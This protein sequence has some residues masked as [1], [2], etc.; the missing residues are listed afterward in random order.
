[1]LLLSGCS[2][3][4]ADDL[5]TGKDGAGAPNDASTDGAGEALARDG[6]PAA[7]DSDGADVTQPTPRRPTGPLEVTEGS[8]ITARVQGFFQLEM[9]PTSGFTPSRL[10]DLG[11]PSYPS[12]AAS[13]FEPIATV[14]DGAVVGNVTATNAGYFEVL[15]ETPA[16]FSFT[17]YAHRELASGADAKTTVRCSIYA[18]GRVVLQTNIQNDGTAPL[19]LPQGWRHSSF[20]VDPTKPWRV[21]AGGDERSF[22]FFHEEPDGLGIT[23]LLHEN[24]SNSGARS[25][26]ERNWI[27]DAVSLAPM[28]ALTKVSELQLGVTPEE[29]SARVADAHA[30]ELGVLS[31][32]TPRDGGFDV[33]SGAYRMSVVG[34]APLA[35]FELTPVH[36]RAYPAFE[37]HQLAAPNGWRVTLDGQT[38]ASSASPV[39]PLGVAHY[40]SE[41]NRLLVVYLGTIPANATIDDRTFTLERL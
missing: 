14:I 10:R 23:A 12:L 41:E 29:A 2:L 19:V 33:R 30:P 27:G 13:L 20:S 31:G 4:L 6:G 1:M 24:E 34:N 15:D 25:N 5:S 35:K 3:L 21:V 39:T 9:L 28:Q 8:P 32:V 22:T 38:V 17:G 26:H 36:A 16:R 40:T 37:I 7:D 11:I 18:S